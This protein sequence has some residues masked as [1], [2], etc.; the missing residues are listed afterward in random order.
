[1]LDDFIN[2]NKLEAKLV[3]AEHEVRGKKKVASLAEVPEENVIK[4]ILYNGSDNQY[5]LAVLPAYKKADLEKLCALQDCEQAMEIE[6]DET[7]E[8]TGYS[9]GAIPPISVYG[10]ELFVDKS[11]MRLDKVACLA[12]DEKT[13]L[14][15]SPNEIIESAWQEPRVEEIT[16]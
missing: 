2:A 13:V 16:K 7:E 9:K 14:V 4:V 11:V 6:E 12:A 5:F 8:I 3:S 15:I 1:M 10:I